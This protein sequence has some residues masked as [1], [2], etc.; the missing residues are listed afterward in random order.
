MGSC[1]WVTYKCHLA[2]LGHFHGF[3]VECSLVSVKLTLFLGGHL[4]GKPSVHICKCTH[5]PC[6]FYPMSFLPFV[7]SGQSNMW[8]LGI[9][10]IKQVVFQGTLFWHI[11]VPKCVFKNTSLFVGPIWN[12]SNGK[13]PVFH[14][15]GTCH[16][17][18]NDH[19]HGFGHQTHQNHQ[20][21]IKP[22]S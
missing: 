6:P 20:N 14:V 13:Y 19:F 5:V 2:V 10:S 21:D 8:F 22:Y 15:Y 7:T 16:I 3:G 4:Q 1:V 18:Q 11:K 12:T 17:C 9:S